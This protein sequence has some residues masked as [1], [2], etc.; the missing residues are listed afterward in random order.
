MAE[1]SEDGQEKTEEPTAKK[2]EKAAE[3]GQV[4][5]SKEMF[6]FTGVFVMFGL[7][8]ILP[9]FSQMLISYWSM[10][11][12]WSDIV[13]DKK[14]ILDI[15]SYALRFFLM[16]I[17]FISIPM[18]IIV[19]LT[20]IAV[21]G[22]NFAPKAMQFKGKKINPI[23]G[24]KRMFSQKALAELVKAV[25]KVLLL[26]GLTALVVYDRLDDMIQLTERELSQA[27]VVM[28]ESFPKLIFVLAI[29]LAII[30]AIDYFWQRHIF[31]QGLRM[32]KQEIKD[33]FKQTEGSPEVKAKIR[34]KQME[35]SANTAKQ[36]AALEDVPNATAVITNPTHFAIAL[37]YE[38]GSKGAP[39]ILAMGKGSMAKAIIERAE[40]ASVTLFRSPLL[41]RA[42]F[43]TG[44]IGQEIND[45][46]YTAVAV[47]LAY[48]FKLDRGEFA[49]EPEITI[50][51]DLQFTE[52]GN[53]IKGQ[54]NVK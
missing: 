3:D 37:K 7:V 51:D 5:S 54:E 23:E 27:V 15:L 25:L 24:F 46:L 50:P 43:F 29:G 13:N 10:F 12:D 14:S 28:G 36:A 32:T 21:G 47:A 4:L 45:K 2:L 26:F 30:A 48:I 35:A 52:E 22:I 33:E 44:E 38:V 20:Q 6:V 31:I 42:L 8:Y 53:V 18:F 16:V 11:F 1:Q 34:R 9:Y 40:T 39:T 49:S 41:A 19:L 17:L